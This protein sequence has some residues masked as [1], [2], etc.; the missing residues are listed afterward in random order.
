MMLVKPDCPFS[1]RDLIQHLDRAK[2][3]S[4]V[5]FGGNL[6]RQPAFV[7][8]RQQSPDA[9]RFVGDLTGADRIMN[10]AVFVGSYPG[11]TR[12]MLDYIIEQIHAFVKAS[13]ATGA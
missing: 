2:I 7:T 13:L 3:G 9:F 1:R 4:R 6:V 10:E 8:L 11:L 5:L 12:T